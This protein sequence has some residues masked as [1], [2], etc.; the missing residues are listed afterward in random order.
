MKRPLVS[1]MAST[2]VTLVVLA[3]IGTLSGAEFLFISSVFESLFA[4]IAI[5][6]GFLIMRKYESKYAAFEVML[7][8]TYTIIVLAILGAIFNWFANGTPIWGLVIMAVVI[9]LIGFFLSLFRMR[10]DIKIINQLLQKRNKKS[11][12]TGD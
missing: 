7:D 8:I 4:N 9:Y 1:I 10:E 6:S 5:H 11:N 2:G 3:V 12:S